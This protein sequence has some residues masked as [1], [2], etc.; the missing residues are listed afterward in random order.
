MTDRFSF[1]S[2]GSAA[3]NTQQ[4]LTEQE[5][6]TF[7]KSLVEG[8][9]HSANRTQRRRTV[10]DATHFWKSLTSAPLATPMSM[11]TITGSNA[12]SN[13]GGSS[14]N[15][16]NNS[17]A[18]NNSAAGGGSSSSLTST[19]TTSQ[20]ATSFKAAK[21]AQTILALTQSDRTNL[22]YRPRAL[23]LT[24]T[25][26]IG[27]TT[28]SETEKWKLQ[29]AMRREEQ[30]ASGE[31]YNQAMLRE[32]KIC[33]GPTPSESFPAGRGRPVVATAGK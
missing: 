11:A 20:P 30:K 23:A 13:S 16:T 26:E 27:R 29:A 32:T 4:S 5:V 8:T 21:E 24:N 14:S 18:A 33:K 1:A 31:K 9:S 25:I 10:Q 3:T 19:P 2:Q 6:D 12:A 28:L 7:F 22:L 17:S 15:T